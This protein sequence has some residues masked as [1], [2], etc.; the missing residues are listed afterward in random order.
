MSTFTLLVTANAFRESGAEAEAP[1]RAAGGEI[2]YPHRMGPLSPEE[3]IPYLRQADAVVAATD[4]YNAEVLAACPR[5]RAVVRWGTGYDSVDLKAC[6]EAGVVAC[7]TPGLNVESVADY[8]FAVMLGLARR[9]PRQIEVMRSGEWAEVR[10]VELFRKTLGL[11]GF[12]AIG[13]AVARRARG[14]ECRVLAYDPLLSPEAVRAHGAEPADLDTVFAEGD[15]VSLH[16]SLTPESRGLV[17][18]RLL[19]LMKPGAFFINA[20]RGPL[21][22]EDALVAALREERIAGAAVDA[23]CEEP[24]PADHPFRRLPNCL[25]TPH[26]AFNTREAVAATN[27]AVVEQAL[28]ALRGERPGFALNPEVWETDRLRAREPILPA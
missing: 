19:G 22:D 27:R 8:V 7:N 1:V 4:P 24:L 11:V 16:A 15:W 2:L 18:A 20:A 17:S 9:L 10:G 14:F 12:G 5:V 13:K 25:A 6:T 23:F 3:L 26:S 28:A 21:V